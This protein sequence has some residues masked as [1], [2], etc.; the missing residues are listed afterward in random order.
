MDIAKAVR[1]FGSFFFPKLAD[2]FGG[3]WLGSL[4][5]YFRHLFWEVANEREEK[6]FNRGDIIDSLL[7]LKHD[8][9]AKEL[10]E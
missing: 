4:A 5:D 3:S 6:N 7:A 2:F 9:Q 8:E 10:G 1:T